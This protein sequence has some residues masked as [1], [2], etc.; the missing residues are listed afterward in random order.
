MSA[1]I[2]KEL[3]IDRLAS[4]GAGVGRIDG[5]ACFVPFSAPGDLLKVKIEKEHRS[6]IEASIDEIVIPSSLR[7]EPFCPH[8]GTCGGCDWQHLDYDLQC[9]AKQSILYDA[10]SRIGCIS[11]PPV[12]KTVK[13]ASPRSYR[14]RA[15]FKLHASSFGLH[16]GFFKKG[17]RHVVDL[18]AGC[19]LVTDFVNSALFRLKQL[20]ATLPDAN[21]IPQITIDNG[22]EG[23]FAI[24][25]YIGENK[26]RLLNLLKNSEEELVL[27]GLFLQAGRKDSITRVFGNRRITYSVPTGN[28]IMNLA[29]EM[30][31]FSQVNR[32]QNMEMAGIVRSLALEARRS[33]LL[34][35]YCGNG[36]L[37]LPL[38]DIVSSITG[39]EEY[40]PSVA[41]AV[42]NSRQASVNNSTFICSDSAE[43]V[44]AFLKSGRHFDLVL[45]DPPRG[46]AGTL[47]KNIAETAA[48]DIIYVSCDPATLSRDLAFL[49][50]QKLYSLDTAI[51]LDMFPHTAHLETIA[52]LKR[53]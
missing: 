36:N 43:A 24:I 39:V 19:P 2:L 11:D 41:S 4:G 7:K 6:W 33:H 26:E 23:V 49:T 29:Y 8:F 42:D 13:A 12:S 22:D 44:N 16:A 30:G 18:P 9:D 38:S 52:R 47:I 27:A 34:D 17:S 31:S 40:E 10:I 53:I 45:L 32:Q 50:G 51:P 15:Q 48:E 28:G 21:R 46:G 37:C 14:A 20:I 35:L 1:V 25:H 3:S 5:K